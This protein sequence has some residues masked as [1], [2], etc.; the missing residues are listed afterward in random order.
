VL[1]SSEQIL[2]ARLLRTDGGS[3]AE[4][5]LQRMFAASRVPAMYDMIRAVRGSGFRSAAVQLPGMRRVPARISRPV[6]A[7][8]I[9][10]ECGMRKPEQ[11]IFLHTAKSLGRSPSRRLHRR[12]RGERKRGRRVRH[13]RRAPHRGGPTVAALRS[14][15]ACRS[16]GRPVAGARP[17]NTMR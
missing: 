15:S 5:L 7:V 14:C 13:D 10:G 6:D 17:G 9:S 3:T 11:A 16:T 2:A 12:Y 8:V 4:G 1:P